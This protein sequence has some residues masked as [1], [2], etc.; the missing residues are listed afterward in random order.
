MT[1]THFHHHTHQKALG[2][3]RNPGKEALT[4]LS[5]MGYPAFAMG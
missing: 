1:G 3:W 2:P 4:L 5:R